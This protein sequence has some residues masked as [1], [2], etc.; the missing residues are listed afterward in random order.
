MR[1]RN[2]RTS[3]RSY[4]RADWLIK[5]PARRVGA[6]ARSFAGAGGDFLVGEG[7]ERGR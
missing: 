1:T 6:K 7:G 2:A 3:S 4:I 5:C